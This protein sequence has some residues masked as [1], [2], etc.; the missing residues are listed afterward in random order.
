MPFRRLPARESGEADPADTHRIGW[1]NRQQDSQPV[2]VCLRAGSRRDVLP[3]LGLKQ[4]AVRSGCRMEGVLRLSDRLGEK[5]ARQLQNLVGPAQ[6]LVLALQLLHALR[7][8]C[9]YPRARASVN[10]IALDPAQQRLRHAADLRGHR[11]HRRPQ[12]WV[13]SCLSMRVCR[14]RNW[15][16]SNN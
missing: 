2:S 10:L 8:R 9:C 5:R 14:S 15:T 7:L 11:F 12:R 16:R 4:V 6:L 1:R 3:H 13:T